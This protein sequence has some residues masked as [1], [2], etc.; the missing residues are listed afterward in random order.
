MR[1]S[2]K[3]RIGQFLRGLLLAT[4]AD[5][6]A[7]GAF[8]ID[9]AWIEWLVAVTFTDMALVSIGFAFGDGQTRGTLAATEDYGEEYGARVG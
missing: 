3:Q 7:P 8:G 6:A 1:Y 4:F 5:L 9:L 2:S